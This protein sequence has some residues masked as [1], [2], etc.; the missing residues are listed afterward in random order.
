MSEYLVGGQL[1]N[2]IW[3]LNIHMQFVALL[4]FKQVVDP[5]IFIINSNKITIW[6]KKMVCLKYF[7]T[8][9]VN[10]TLS[11]LLELH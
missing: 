3:V 5:G 8:A 7:Q 9:Q 4:A 10:K 2:L 1:Q 6:D 11:G